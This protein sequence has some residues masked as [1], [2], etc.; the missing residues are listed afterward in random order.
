[1]ESRGAFG[2]SF[3]FSQARGVTPTSDSPGGQP[4][5]LFGPVTN[6]SAWQL[7]GPT[8]MPPKEETASTSR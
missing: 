7:S 1:M 3:I 4:R 2:L 5:H 6:R 8:S